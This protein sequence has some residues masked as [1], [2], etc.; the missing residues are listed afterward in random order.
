M[1]EDDKKP[2]EA[3]APGSLAPAAGG[4][5]D[6]AAAKKAFEALLPAYRAMPASK[7]KATRP[8]LTEVAHYVWGRAKELQMPTVRAKF[9]LL[10]KQL[11]DI[12]VL[13]RLDQ[14]ALGALYAQQLLESAEAQTTEARVSYATLTEATTVKG[15]M[16]KASDY[17]LRHRRPDLALELDDIISGTGHADLASD[18]SRLQKLYGDEKAHF[19]HHGDDPHYHAGDADRAGELSRRILD[20]MTEGRAKALLEARDIA[21]RAF[22]VVWDAWDV[23]GGGGQLALKDE[24]G[25]KLFP[26]LFQVGRAAPARRKAGK[27]KGVEPPVEG[28]A[29]AVG[30]APEPK[31]KRT[32][33]RK[34][35]RR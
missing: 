4:K 13:D 10:P 22:T 18:L 26:S 6:P 33:S 8:G 34:K 31:A 27:D 19:P 24:G 5:I 20:E 12:G 9:A 35:P 7:V 25:A 23:I 28:G 21:A 15:R 29:A 11:F 17:H 30:G 1:K 2:K 3:K 14:F 16:L 32:R